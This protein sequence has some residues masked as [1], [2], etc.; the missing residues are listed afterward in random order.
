MK[1]RYSLAVYEPG[2]TTRITSVKVGSD[3]DLALFVQDL[4]EVERNQSQQR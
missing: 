2:T 4:L 1:V 3:F